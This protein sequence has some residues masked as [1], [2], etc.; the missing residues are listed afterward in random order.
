[1]NHP[2]LNL[3][4]FDEQPTPEGSDEDENHSKTIHR[5][6][7][8]AHQERRHNE[9]SFML[10]HKFKLKTDYS[11]SEIGDDVDNKNDRK[12][13]YRVSKKIYT[14][15]EIRVIREAVLKDRKK[16]TKKLCHY[17]TSIVMILSIL[18]M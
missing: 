7:L 10:Q 14:P 1:M 18:A 6:E 12:I 15:E 11:E 8:G 3:Q 4:S 9:S 5:S 2:N 13:L 16:S 17:F